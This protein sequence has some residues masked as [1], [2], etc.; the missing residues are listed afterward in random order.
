[1]AFELP[2]EDPPQ[3]CGAALHPHGVEAEPCPGL[4]RA[5]DDDCAGLTAKAV[6]EEPNPAGV[7]FSESEGKGI[8]DL[9]GAQP[10]ILVPAHHDICPEACGVE[11]PQ[12]A[13]DAVTGDDQ[14]GVRQSRSVHDFALELNIDP[15]LHRPVGQDVDQETAADAEAMVA[16]DDGTPALNIH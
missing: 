7:R 3:D 5:L 6:R 13:V 16:P 8:E 15:E 1:M 14:V 4:W 10:G 2:P 9:A 12:P 11:S